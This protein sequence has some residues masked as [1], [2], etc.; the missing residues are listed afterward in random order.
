MRAFIVELENRP[1]ML[2]DLCETM[3][4]RG[5]NITGVA[6]TTVGDEGGIALVT[7][8]EGSTR[9]IHEEWDDAY[10]EVEL[11]S[12]RLEDRAG[13]LADAARRLADRD[14]NIDLVM[15]MGMSGGAVTVGFGVDDPTA[16][17]EALGELVAAGVA[18]G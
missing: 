14:V 2:A 10:R 12:A 9:D 4:Q 7:S 5:I 8:D 1:G 17:R 16:A 18:T 6:A 11:V 15:P 13:T 3:A